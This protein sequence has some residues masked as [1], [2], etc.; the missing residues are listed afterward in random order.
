MTTIR[1]KMRQNEDLPENQ[2]ITCRLSL[3]MSVNK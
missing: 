2:T 1:I 3:T